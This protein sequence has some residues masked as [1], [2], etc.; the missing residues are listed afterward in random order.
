MEII[1]RL[2]KARRVMSGAPVVD[3]EEV[4]LRVCKLILML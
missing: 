2:A 4:E 3:P 1:A